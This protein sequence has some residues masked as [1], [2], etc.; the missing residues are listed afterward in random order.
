MM[1]SAILL[2]NGSIPYIIFEDQQP[3]TIQ[4]LE[5]H[6]S[7][8]RLIAI[9]KIDHDI[10]TPSDLVNIANAIEHM[11]LCNY[12]L[13]GSYRVESAVGFN[14]Y[15]TILIFKAGGS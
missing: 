13:I 9:V 6:Y 2:I 4:D 8:N 7:K 1:V 11:K 14:K 12:E 3:E 10:A 15:I 5:I